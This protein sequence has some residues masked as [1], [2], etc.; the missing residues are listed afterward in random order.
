MAKIL[1]DIRRT[2]IN[3]LQQ[4]DQQEYLSFSRMQYHSSKVSK[5]W[6]KASCIESLR[7]VV[8]NPE[9]NPIEHIWVS[10]STLTARYKSSYGKND[11]RANTL[12]ETLLKECNK[13]GSDNCQ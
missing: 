7:K 5:A 10:G 12:K 11:V 1:S 13:Y 9:M 2:T 6:N 3:V 8:R 4:S